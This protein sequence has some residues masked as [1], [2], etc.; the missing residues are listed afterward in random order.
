MNGIGVDM[1]KTTETARWRATVYYRSDNGLVDVEHWLE[2]VGDIEAL[3]EAGP[4]WDTVD[5]I[6]IERVNHCDS[7][8]LTVEQALTL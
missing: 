5:R 7:P 3:V 6:E 8:T 2:E 4:H 1:A